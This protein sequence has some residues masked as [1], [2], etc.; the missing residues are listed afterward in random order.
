MSVARLS[1]QGRNSDIAHYFNIWSPP[2]YFAQ[3]LDSLV[4]EW[5]LDGMFTTILI[6]D[7]IEAKPD[8]T[9]ISLVVAGNNRNN[10]PN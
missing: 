10:C 6:K 3:Y 2:Q 5:F 7:I 9:L 1:V 4:F 8:R